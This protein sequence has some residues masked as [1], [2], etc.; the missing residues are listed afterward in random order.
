MC[1]CVCVYAFVSFER[2]CAEYLVF[3]C[4]L[5]FGF[6]VVVV[7]CFFSSTEKCS[8]T[9]FMVQNEIYDNFM[10][11]IRIPRKKN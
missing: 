3:M 7:V 10:E 11:I 4:V 6:V 9:I 1:V 8:Q 2:M 5:D